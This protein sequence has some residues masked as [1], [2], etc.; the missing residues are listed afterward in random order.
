MLAAVTAAGLSRPVDARSRRQAGGSPLVAKRLL[1]A[2]AIEGLSTCLN[3]S[4][5]LSWFNEW[6]QLCEGELNQI[7]PGPYPLATEIRAQPGY[8]SVSS[9]RA[10]V[11]TLE[12]Q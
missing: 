7:S 4:T 12:V 5:E 9:D 8:S 6:S 1:E 3:K 11:Q 10:D 2:K